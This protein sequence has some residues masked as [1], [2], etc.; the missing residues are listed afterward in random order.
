M[1]ASGDAS[2]DQLTANT[3]YRDIF[4]DA[5]LEKLQDDSTK[6]STA[7][8]YYASVNFDDAV[9]G[10]NW[11][12]KLSDDQSDTVNAQIKAASD[13]GLKSRYWNTPGSPSWIRTGVEGTLVNDKV[14]MLNVDDV[15]EARGIITGS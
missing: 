10:V 1:V 8:S 12:G 9:G 2:F 11:L 13:L 6:Y 3:T 7:D 4:F 15:Q 5:P 14:G